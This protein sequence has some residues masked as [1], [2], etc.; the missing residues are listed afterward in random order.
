MGGGDGRGRRD[1]RVVTA[2]ADD[3]PHAVEVINHTDNEGDIGG[4]LRSD[5]GWN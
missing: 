3:F 4:K 1:E 2:Y 5:K